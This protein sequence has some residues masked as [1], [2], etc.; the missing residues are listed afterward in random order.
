MEATGPV[1]LQ[2]FRL[3]LEADLVLLAILLTVGSGLDMGWPVDW[4][5]VQD[6]LQLM[7]EFG[8]GQTEQGLVGETCP[9]E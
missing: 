8:D 5:R 2:L 1:L 7:R 9:F 3:A 6:W 4:G